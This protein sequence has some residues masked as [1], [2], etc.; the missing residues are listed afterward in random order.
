MQ[1]VI[2]CGGL[3]T[4]LHPITEKIPK[5]LIEIKGKPILY[6]QIKLLKKQGIKD[7]I[8]CVG[9]LSE[10]IIDYFKDGKK[11]GVE[12]RYSLEDRALGTAGAV[13][14]INENLLQKKFFVL[15]GDVITDVSFQDMR[16]YHEN[17]NSAATILIREKKKIGS[18][19]INLNKNFMITDFIERPSKDQ[20]EY[21]K[22]L[23]K[24]NWVNSGLYLLDKE[25]LDYIPVN[26]KFDFAYDLFPSLIKEEENVF[27]FPLNGFWRELGK[28]DRIES[29]QK[30]IGVF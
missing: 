2:V 11:F 16:N 17:N 1:V 8:L 23:G 24:K 18:S 13:K 9:H 27:G 14:N 4:R 20:I 7:I 22:N 21:F 29:F 26:K 3:A 30:A 15:Y 25:K 6:Y 19:L 5:S 28:I 12:L 10:K